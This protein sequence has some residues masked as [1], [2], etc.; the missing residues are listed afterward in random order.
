M[1]EYPHFPAMRDYE[2]EEQSNK[3]LANFNRIHKL[4]LS[5]KCLSCHIIYKI[6]W[7]HWNLW[8]LTFRGIRRKP[9]T[10]YEFILRWIIFSNGKL[11]YWNRC[12]QNYIPTNKQTSHNPWK[13]AIMNLIDYTCGSNRNFLRFSRLKGSR[14]YDWCGN[15]I[16]KINIRLI[17]Y[18]S[19]KNIF[20][21]SIYRTG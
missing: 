8:W 7:N 5:D 18:V 3:C 1:L 9:P 21:I 11:S 2:A 15:R 20:I 4:L 17:I 16:K 12:P 10:P 6:L 14:S 19:F 13:W